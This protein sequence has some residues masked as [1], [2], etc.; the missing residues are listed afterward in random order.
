MIKGW[1]FHHLSVPV[2]YC[3]PRE[4]QYPIRISQTETCDLF[5]A[6]SPV[7]ENSYGTERAQSWKQC[8]P[9]VYSSIKKKEVIFHAPAGHRCI[10]VC[11][12]QDENTFLAHI[13]I[14]V[15]YKL[16]FLFKSVLLSQDLQPVLIKQ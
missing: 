9:G 11:H 1:T 16:Q 3:L 5:P 13:W 8:C 4:V 7:S 10:P 15:L 6:P 14:G 2:L 12:I